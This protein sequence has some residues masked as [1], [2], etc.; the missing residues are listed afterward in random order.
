MRT[1][2]YLIDNFFNS[3]FECFKA[4]IF[5]ILRQV[6]RN[7]S[8]NPRKI[9]RWLIYYSCRSSN[10]LM[11]WIKHFFLNSTKF[12]FTM[13][14]K[15]VNFCKYVFIKIENLFFKMKSPSLFLILY[16][17]KQYKIVSPVNLLITTKGENGTNNPR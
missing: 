7:T 5:P 10:K 16:E 3:H 15:I 13:I 9:I 6:V 1:D 12:Q 17:F 8:P 2:N 4:K 11:T 14:W